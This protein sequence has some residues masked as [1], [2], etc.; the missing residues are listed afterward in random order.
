MR[1]SPLRSATGRK[2]IVI[3]VAA[4]LLTPSFSDG[5]NQNKQLRDD[6]RF[7]SSLYGETVRDIQTD[8]RENLRSL[9]RE[10]TLGGFDSTLQLIGLWGYDAWY[11]EKEA[12]Y[13]GIVSTRTVL[14]NATLDPSDAG[15]LLGRGSCADRARE[16]W[17]WAERLAF[18][19]DLERT[20]RRTRWSVLYF[21]AQSGRDERIPVDMSVIVYP[22]PRDLIL[23]TT[24]PMKGTSS[25]VSI[26]GLVGG[27][28]TLPGQTQAN[29][30][31]CAFGTSAASAQV[32]VTAEGP[33]GPFSDSTTSDSDGRWSVCLPGLQAGYYQFKAAEGANNA[34][35]R[36]IGL[37]ARFN[38]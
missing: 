18:A 29:A 22:N 1:S 19:K 27:A 4:L 20:L 9:P 16:E 10:T 35:P 15:S 30:S 37:Q 11:E 13:D 28:Y 31:A 23:F 33:G 3:A 7:I 6:L 2:L 14:Q 17:L 26:A 12:Y 5:G 38:F 32:D 34:Q 8:L 36:E 21:N 25:R 24:P